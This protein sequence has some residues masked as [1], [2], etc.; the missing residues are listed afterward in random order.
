MAE[1][2]IVLNL[3]AGVQSSTVFLMAVNG[4]L[5]K[6][7]CAIFA[8]TGWEPHGVYTHLEWL[9]SEGERSG[10]PIH[11]VSNGNIRDDAMRR[12]PNLGGGGRFASMPLYIKSCRLNALCER[13][14]WA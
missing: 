7:H 1:K 11:V 4:A 5:I 10:I 2:I 3:G 9:K 6:P 8:D 13:K 12:Q 14:S